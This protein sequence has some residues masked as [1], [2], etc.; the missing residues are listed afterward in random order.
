MR[1]FRFYKNKQSD[2]HAHAILVPY[3]LQTVVR[4]TLHTNSNCECFYELLCLMIKNLPK[5]GVELRIDFGKETRTIAG[6]IKEHKVR[7]NKG[8]DKDYLLIGLMNV[9]Y[10]LIAKFPDN[11]DEVGKEMLNE[12]LHK[13]LFE[14]PDSENRIQLAS[15]IP[16]KCKSEASRKAALNLLFMLCRDSPSTISKALEYLMPIHTK[17][18]WR[19]NRRSDWAIVAES[20]E[21]STTGYVGLK[22][23]GAIC[24]MNSLLQQFYMIPSCL[25]YTSDAADE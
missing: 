7:E 2:I 10:E 3:M 8:T 16:P 13:C 17:A 12:V 4:E 18:S 24:Y 21:K 20:D 23:L 22:N 15:S 6:Y 1:I 5:E 11:R 14:F 25:L 19:T 9:L